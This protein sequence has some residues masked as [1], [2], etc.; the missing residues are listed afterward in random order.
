M[1]VL[2][3]LSNVI[4]FD[5]SNEVKRAAI[6]VIKKIFESFQD[7]KS[8]VEVR[9]N[10]FHDYICMIMSMVIGIATPCVTVVSFAETCL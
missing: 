9:L 6:T 4:H 10:T 3:L 8:S 5:T 1:Q 7:Q 2:S